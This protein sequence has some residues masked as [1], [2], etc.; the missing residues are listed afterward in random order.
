MA[1]DPLTPAVS[2]RICLH[3]NDDHGEAVLSYARH[4]GGIKAAQAAR[5]LEVRPEAMELEVDG[6]TVEIPFDHPLTDSEDAH[7]TLVAMLRA[8]PRG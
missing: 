2:A 4:Y 8:L 1:S 3:M 7:R 5:M 6:T